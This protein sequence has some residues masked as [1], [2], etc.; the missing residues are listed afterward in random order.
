MPRTKQEVGR[1]K[2]LAGNHST[3]LIAQELG[4]GV[5]ATIAKA[6]ELNISLRKKRALGLKERPAAVIRSGHGPLLRRTWQRQH[7]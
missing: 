3:A 2:D 1:L 7:G 6:T 5:G 4:R